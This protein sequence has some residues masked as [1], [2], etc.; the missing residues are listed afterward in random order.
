MTDTNHTDTNAWNNLG[1]RG[2]PG[3]NAWNNL[4]A[5]GWPYSHIGD[6]VAVPAEQTGNTFLPE[7]LRK[8][9]HLEELADG[10][11]YVSNSAYDSMFVRTDAGVVVVDA[12]ATLAN[13]LL[14]AIHEVTDEPVTHMI[15][16]HH[17]ADHIGAAT[18]FGRD[19][20]ILAHEKTRDMLTRFPDP[21]RPVPTETFSDTTTLD[22]GGVQLQLDYKG[23]NH[24]EGN[25]FIYAPN[26]KVLAAID[27]ITPGWS[28]F[29][30]CDASENIR[31]WV[32]AHDQILEYDF[33]AVVC[34][35]LNRWGT[36]EDAKTAREYVNDMV[37]FGKEALEQ[38]SDAD[39]VRRVGFHHP[40][41]VTENWL[42][43]MANYVTHKILEKK[44]SNGQYWTERLA[45]VDTY[46]K[47]HA[48][49]IVQQLRLEWGVL[50]RF[51]KRLRGED[52]VPG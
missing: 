27:I 26:Q 47:Y 24:C 5:R 29:R 46:T 31:G 9:Y 43:D 40:W 16:S 45:G 33:D 42:N 22:V 52:P 28:T 39:V 4:G 36:K 15:Y 23:Q 13:A 51:D 12:P 17:H 8:G 7:R 19:V 3:T 35:H 30:H 10:V 44:T 2:W 14:P 21:N 11:Y 48:Y 20:T 25:T 38:V 50:G 34:G 49:T 37:E 18:V 6:F 1:A 41:V 32:Q